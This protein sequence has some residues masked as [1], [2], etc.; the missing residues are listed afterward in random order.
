MRDKQFHIRV[1]SDELA[2]LKVLA[3]SAGLSEWARGVL[4][5]VNVYT[6]KDDIKDAVYTEPIIKQKRVHKQVETAPI[7]VHTPDSRNY[8]GVTF[9]T[10][11]R[12]AYE[13]ESGG[14]LLTTF[15]S[16]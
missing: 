9:K 10:M 3:G 7:R 6:K 12:T 15:E 16:P 5:T 1:S 2:Q 8:T 4:L 11:G 13:Y 14:Q